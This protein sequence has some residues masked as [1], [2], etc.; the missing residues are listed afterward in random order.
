MDYEP[1]PSYIFYYILYKDYYMVAKSKNLYEIVGHKGNS[2]NPKTFTVM[3]NDLPDAT[4]LADS[5][6]FIT[7]L[8][9]VHLGAIFYDGDEV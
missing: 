1:N 4:H 8:S 3:A 6:L 5:G 7:I 9:I 2:N